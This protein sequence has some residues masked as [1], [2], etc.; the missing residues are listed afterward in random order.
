MPRKISVLLVAALLLAACGDEP[1]APVAAPPATPPPAAPLSDAPTI[2][3]MSIHEWGVIDVP[4]RRGVRRPVAVTGVPGR[5]T[6]REELLQ[7]LQMPTKQ[8]QLAQP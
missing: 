7:D 1:A 8:G 2:E 5:G 3:G 6:P 4:M